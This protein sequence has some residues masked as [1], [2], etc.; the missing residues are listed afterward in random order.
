MPDLSLISCDG[1]GQSA[2]PEHIAH[3]LQRLEW[4]TRYRPI[5]LHTLLLGA[6]SPQAQAEFLYSPD[7]GHFGEAAQLIAAVGIDTQN[8]SVDAIH[9][10]FQRRGLFLAHI[11]ECPLDQGVARSGN[12]QIAT[13]TPASLLSSRLP[14]MLTRIRR[15]LKPKRLAFISAALSPLIEKFAAAQLG[16]DLILD[17]GRP[18][19]LD[20][21]NPAAVTRTIARLHEL[22]AAPA[23]R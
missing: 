12:A 16:C 17:D 14:T 5:H 11:L 13:P 15:S 8:K 7:G 2:S 19:S 10:E 4:A 6:I 9:S 23:T 3:R 21:S 20:G 22:L 18:F 1:C